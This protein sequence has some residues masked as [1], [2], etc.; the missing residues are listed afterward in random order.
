MSSSTTLA[1]WLADS[2]PDPRQVW[3]DWVAHGVSIIP[4]GT[5]FS[6]VRIPEAIVHAAVETTSSHRIGHILADRLDGPVIHDGRGRNFYPLL[7]VEARLDWGTTAP[8]VEHLAPGT[9]LG[10]PALTLDRYTPATPIYWAVAGYSPR[11]CDTAATAL[12]VRVGAAR[13]EEAAADEAAS[14]TH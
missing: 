3:A 1:D 5:L 8:D 13:L 12:L 11:H 14:S 7:R 10:V 2:H 9:H 4:I 6:A